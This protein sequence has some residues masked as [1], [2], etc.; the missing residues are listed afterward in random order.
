MAARY[1]GEEGEGREGV[2]ADGF[3]GGA[4]GE[5]GEGGVWGGEPGAGGG[6]GF[7]SCEVGYLSEGGGGGHFRGLSKV[8]MAARWGNGEMSTVAR[9]QDH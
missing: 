2:D 4:G 9:F 3:V 8:L 1:G 6:G 7:E 5:E